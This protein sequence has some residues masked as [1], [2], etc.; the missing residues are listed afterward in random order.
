MIPEPA[1]QFHDEWPKMDADFEEL[2][3]Q[4]FD[5]ARVAFESRPAD[6]KADEPEPGIEASE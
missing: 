3:R 6:R 1:K 2:K 5:V 4:G